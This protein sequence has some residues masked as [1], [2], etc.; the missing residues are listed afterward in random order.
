MPATFTPYLES[1]FRRGLTDSDAFLRVRVPD[2]PR[3]DGSVVVYLSDGTALVVNG[4][5]LLHLDT[6]PDCPDV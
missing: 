6:R 3:P 1:R 4:H 2:G 5:Q